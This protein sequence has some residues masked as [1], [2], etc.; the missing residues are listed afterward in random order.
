MSILIETRLERD[1]LRAKLDQLKQQ[2][3]G[4]TNARDE[5]SL[6]FSVG[7]L[8]PRQLAHVMRALYL[9][10]KAVSREEV[11]VIV[12]NTGRSLK[13]QPTKVVDVAICRLNKRIKGYGLRVRNLRGVGFYF[14]AEDKSI[15]KTLLPE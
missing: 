14:N 10:P 7:F 3:E 4:L 9:E 15:I 13:N 5:D 1:E 11:L 2:L 8:L 6:P 12:N